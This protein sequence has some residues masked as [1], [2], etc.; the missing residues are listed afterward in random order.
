MEFQVPVPEEETDHQRLR[1]EDCNKFIVETQELQC[2][3]YCFKVP[4]NSFQHPKYRYNIYKLLTVIKALGSSMGG[5]V[6]LCREPGQIG[7]VKLGDVLVFTERLKQ[8]ILNG[9]PSCATDMLQCEHLSEDDAVWGIILVKV[10]RP[11]DLSFQVSIGESGL[12]VFRDAFLAVS[13]SEESNAASISGDPDFTAAMPTGQ[14]SET[15]S[16]PVSTPESVSG[17]MTDWEIEWQLENKIAWTTHKKN[18][19]QYVGLD[20]DSSLES[21]I[22]KYAP[23]SPIFMPSDP[24]IFSPSY[25]LKTLMD[26]SDRNRMIE[27]MRAKLDSPRA[28]AIVSPSWLNHI[29]KEERFKRPSNHV[30]D[31]LVVTENGSIYLWTIVECVGTA[32]SDQRAYMLITG[33]LTKFLLLKD[34]MERFDLRV[35]CYLYNLQSN[36]VEEPQLQ[37]HTKSLFVNNIDF[38]LI[39][40]TLA[41]AIATKETYLR[42]VT[43]EACG[44][45][46]SAEQW[47]I[48]DKINRA[49]VMLVSG[50]PG[51]GKTLLC[52]HFLQE[53]GTMTQCIYVCTNYALAAFMRSQ[54]ISS[55][56][57]VQTDAELSEMIKRG[58]FNDKTCITFDDVHRLSC[59][60]QTVTCLLSLTKN[61]P[62]VRLYVF[63]DNKFQCFDKIKHSF[64]I[65]LERCCQ[66]MGVEL[67][68]HCLTEIHRNTR[69]IMSFLSA[70]SFKGEIKCL[71]KWEGDDVEVLTAENPLDD[72]PDNPVI[73]NILHVLGYT[74]NEKACRLRYTA[75]DIAV[76][77]DT[78]NPE[79]DAQ[80]FQQIL[81]NY[82]PD[83]QVHSAEAYP[84]KGIVVDTLNSFHGLDAG[85]CFYVLSYDK[86]KGKGFFQKLFT[87]ICR[88][89]YNPKYLAFLASRAIYKAVFFVPRL[90]VKVFREMH[91]D[92][93]D[94]QVIF[95]SA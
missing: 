56:Q 85:V 95:S 28:F 27:A 3:E 40:E 42:N 87:D 51:S 88:S 29:G 71:H 52:S 80:Y 30:V 2:P 68:S 91:F 90:D 44:Y 17:P 10:N 66:R 15:E 94:D 34:Q 39:Q 53:K 4:F 45:K 67:S 77:I 24:I 38:R 35:D 49:P 63:C 76:L 20:P 48:A 72:S 26:E 9:N 32:D 50:P 86:V 47:R 1:T 61:H 70:V 13:S 73:Q 46:L 60:D 75:Q 33:R 12:M 83:V 65:V 55:V 58:K 93:F 14:I 18:W 21:H 59:S 57:V 69:R 78:D 62:D 8:W 16:T 19:Q 79:Q 41:Q 81:R 6:V 25:M 64:P 43:G 37:Q 11:T 82:I 22:R 84:R 5:V 92:S 31:I 23:S 7:R 89:I 74:N 36:N 54:N